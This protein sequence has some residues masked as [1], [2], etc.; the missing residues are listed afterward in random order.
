[1]LLCQ[2]DKGESASQ[3]GHASLLES[4]GRGVIAGERAAQ[5][6]LFDRR[7]LGDK[8]DDNSLAVL[9]SRGVG[10]LGV[11]LRGGGAGLAGRAGGGSRGRASSR[12]GNRG[13]AR[14]RRGS[15]G[16]ARRSSGGRR[17][18]GSRVATA[19]AGPSPFVSSRSG[20]F[21][22]KHTSNDF[23]SRQSMQESCVKPSRN[24]PEESSEAAL[25]SLLSPS[26]Q[27]WRPDQSIRSQRA[28]H[29]ASVISYQTHIAALSDA[30]DARVG[31]VA[32]G[33]GDAEGD[34][35]VGRSVNNPWFVVSREEPKLLR[36]TTTLTDRRSRC[37]RCR[38]CL[39]A[40][41]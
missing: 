5:S 28:E 11:V 17:V 22:C 16:S 38:P 33:V 36:T 40:D 29:M 10:L 26:R 31:V 8:D 34:V 27:L 13:R 18:R 41:S 9:G 6:Q 19:G 14:S 7:S 30:Q 24:L 21:S 2:N 37:R 39:P 35:G 32:G 23:I 3:S 15:R 4:R 25:L 20:L 1:M 12:R